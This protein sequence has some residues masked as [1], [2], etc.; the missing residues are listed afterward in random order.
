MLHYLYFYSGLTIH[1]AE[2]IEKIGENLKEVK[3]NFMSVVPRLLEK[4]YD[5]IILKG[6][7]LTGIKKKLFFWAVELGLQ[8]EPYGSEMAGGMK[9]NW[10]WPT[11]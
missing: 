3:P 10:P 6:A 5:S 11:N 2:S 8:Y 9:R 1:F 4:I 7:D